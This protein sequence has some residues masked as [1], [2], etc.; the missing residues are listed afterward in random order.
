MMDSAEQKLQREA[1]ELLRMAEEDFAELRK[2]TYIEE[3]KAAGLDDL[4][5]HLTAAEAS[6]GAKVVALMAALVTLLQHVHAPTDA[7]Q[8]E[9]SI[10]AGMLAGLMVARHVH[11]TGAAFSMP[12]A[13]RADGVPLAMR[14]LS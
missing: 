6:A 13:G 4:V 14:D 10:Q 3:V 9:R 8:R 1:F 7:A 5:S 2:P 12:L 11:K